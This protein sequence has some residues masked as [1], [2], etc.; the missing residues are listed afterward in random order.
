MDSIDF[1]IFFTFDAA[2]ARCFGTVVLAVDGVTDGVIDDPNTTEDLRDEIVDDV[3][4]G[5]DD[6][7][8]VGGFGD[9]SAILDSAVDDDAIG[10]CNG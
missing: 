10:L 7:N 3:V 9:E 5:F 8:P 2:N 1:D 6:P 4:N